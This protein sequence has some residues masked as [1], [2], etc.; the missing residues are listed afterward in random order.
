MKCMFCQKECKIDKEATDKIVVTEVCSNHPYDV[1]HYYFRK[2]K[3]CL[4]RLSYEFTVTRNDAS[5][6]FTFHHTESDVRMEIWKGNYHEPWNKKPIVEF[7]YI[8]NITPEN[9]SEKLPII[10]TFL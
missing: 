4:I 3:T 10:L 9:A 1:R 8:P 2:Q 5:Y 7:D 6:N